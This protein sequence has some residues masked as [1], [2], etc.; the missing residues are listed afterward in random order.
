MKPVMLA[1]D[2]SPINSVSSCNLNLIKNPGAGFKPTGNE[3]LD[4][5][6]GEFPE[7]FTQ[8]C[9]LDFNE[10]EYDGEICY[11]TPTGVTVVYTS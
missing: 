10:F 2:I 9:D 8:N 11:H 3:D 1:E 6:L 4:G 7:L 5:Y